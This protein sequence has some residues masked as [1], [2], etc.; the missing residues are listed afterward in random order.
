MSKEESVISHNT[1]ETRLCWNPDLPIS[2]TLTIGNEKIRG[3]CSIHNFNNELVS[4]FE[5]RKREGKL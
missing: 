1:P 2:Y 5:K 4:L 3:I